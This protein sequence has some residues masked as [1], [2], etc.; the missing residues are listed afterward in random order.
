MIKTQDDASVWNFATILIY[1]VYNI[2]KLE[3]GSC[4]ETSLIGVGLIIVLFYFMLEDY[5]ILSKI[6]F[7]VLK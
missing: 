3:V 7:E 2:V 1:F 4:W 5:S 6:I